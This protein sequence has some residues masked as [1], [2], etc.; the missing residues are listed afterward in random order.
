M[1]RFAQRHLPIQND[2]N[3]FQKPV[4]ES[5]YILILVFYKLEYIFGSLLSHKPHGQIE[6]A[7]D[8]V[9]TMLQLL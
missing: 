2:N 3:G 4:D 6:P 7:T 5:D 1:E 9:L 8:N